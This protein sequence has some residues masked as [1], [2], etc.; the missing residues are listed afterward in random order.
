M[1]LATSP[2][3]AQGHCPVASSAMP[4]AQAAEGSTSA[5]SLV[6]C[7]LHYQHCCSRWLAAV[8]AAAKC[9][10]LILAKALHGQNWSFSDHTTCALMQVQHIANS[11]E[12]TGCSSTAVSQYHIKCCTLRLA[13]TCAARLVH[14]MS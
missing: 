3:H 2:S 4:A 11:N 12:S 1:P 6:C 10:L 5:A 8:L 9:E 13:R 7:A 14:R